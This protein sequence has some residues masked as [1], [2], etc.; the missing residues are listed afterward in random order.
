MMNGA[1]WAIVVILALSVL[2]GLWRGLVREAMSLVTWLAAVVAAIMFGA[3]VAALYGTWIDLP[4]ARVGLGYLTVFLLVLLVGSLIGWLVRR[5][6]HGTGLSGTDRVLGLGFGA[7]RGGLM[8]AAL[9]LVLGYTPFAQDPWW[10]QSQLIPRFEPAAEW[11]REQIPDTLAALKALSPPEELPAA[12]L[13]EP[14][15]PPA[16][17]LR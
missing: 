5:I 1:D 2:V 10:H 14:A 12:A 4:S 6:V 7:L 11:L 15:S 16:T 8:V 13:P 9:V 17:V 3:Q